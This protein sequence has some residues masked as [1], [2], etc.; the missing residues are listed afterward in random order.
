MNLNIFILLQ[1]LPCTIALIEGNPE[2]RAD[3]I[4]GVL[5]GEYRIQYEKFDNM[6]AAGKV[7]ELMLN[8]LNN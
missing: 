2:L 8:I 6:L 1:A 5:V 3:T 7:N 4:R